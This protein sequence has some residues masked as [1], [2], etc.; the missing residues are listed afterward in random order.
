MN[1]RK[2]IELTAA[3]LVGSAAVS[4]VEGE[5]SQ[6]T[7]SR[8]STDSDSDSVT[9]LILYS[10]SSLLDED[11]RRLTDDDSIAVWAAETATNEDKDGNYDHWWYEDDTE[12]PVVAVDDN[13][14][15]FGSTLVDDEN[16][17]PAD[18]AQFVEN[19][20]DEK[21]GDEPTV[22][23]DQS[24][25]S[26]WT[27]DKFSSFEDRVEDSGY[28]LEPTYDLTDDLD[29]ADAV[30]VA[31]PGW[32]FWY[33]DLRALEEFVDSGGVLFL[34]N[35]SDYQNYDE[36]Y[37]LNDICEFLDLS[38]RFN[39]DQVEDSENNT[40]RSYEPTT[41]N[42]N[43]E[44]P[45][46]NSDDD[47]DEDDGEEDDGDE[48]D[49]GDNEEPDGEVAEV[50]SVSDGDT[51]TIDLDGT[52]ER[53][54]I[55][56]HDTPETASNQDAEL[57]QEWEG[58]ESLDT[59]ATWGAN[60][61]DFGKQELSDETVVVQFD[62]NADR[63]D[64]F[65]RLLAY[66]YYDANGDG[67]R[68]DFY[69]L[70]TVEEGYARVYDSAFSKHDSFIEA[71]K[72]ARDA[73]RGLWAES[74]PENSPEIRNDTVEDMF[75]PKASGIKTTGGALPESRTPVLAESTASWNGPT[76]GDGTPLVGV[77]ES[78]SVAMVGAQIISEDYE[79]E[80]G[81]AEDTSSY[82]NFPFLTNLVDALSDSSGEILI[83]GGHG[84]FNADYALSAEDAAY[85][86]RYLEG[87][88]VGF[89]QVNTL[90]ASN[91]EAARALIVTTPA[92]EF[93]DD[94]IDALTSF[95]DSGGAVLLLG[96]GDAPSDGRAN[97]NDVAS[98]LGT[99]LR[100]GSGTVT[101]YQN[102]LN[103]DD[104]LVTTTQFNSSFSLFDAF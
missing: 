90:T 102:N 43:E 20:W 74:D 57:P 12:I 47:D 77:D 38:F 68:D 10:S 36:T 4:G 84:Q 39:D 79:A 76:S 78:A 83:E 59:L 41:D 48:D 11:R 19:V 69:N 96:G 50:L 22:L 14:V 23:W 87:V 35:Q 1:R 81:F 70:R 25:D 88:D 55:L 99:D 28:T 86:Q 17:M 98:G 65:D 58:I 33:Q 44:F 53:V 49:G 63:R 54:R 101:D 32:S 8:V 15:G 45:F 80:E 72:T 52:E 71:E 13:V 92:S 42:F 5:Q 89:E 82:G 30:V 6:V 104:E 91:L 9:E 75:F 51:I 95:V 24:H 62:E 103:Y 100:L 34:I 16:D 18:N 67:S 3:S 97:L 27:L 64:P 7:A 46:F 66:I 2:F 26:Y 94:E 61:S 31:V 56:G 40:G 73:G 21:L 93:D 37:N 60:A 29:D 85:Y